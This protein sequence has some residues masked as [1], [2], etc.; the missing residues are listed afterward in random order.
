VR[1]YIEDRL[2]DPDLSPAAIA[3]AHGVSVRTLQLAFAETGTTVTRHVRDRRLKAC[4][5]DLTRPGPAETVT[6]VAFR[7]GFNDAGHFSRT[8]RQEFGVTPSAVL[9]GARSGDR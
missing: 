9:A 5:R 3:A 2:D 8:F 7:W 4:Y 1:S 6:D